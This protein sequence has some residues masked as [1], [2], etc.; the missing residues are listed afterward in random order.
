MKRILGLPGEEIEVRQGTVYV[1]GKPLS[2]PYVEFKDASDIGPGKLEADHFVAAGDNRRPTLIVVI[3]RKRIVGRWMPL[4]SPRGRARVGRE[5]SQRSRPA[6]G[7]ALA[8]PDR[9]TRF[10]Y[11]NFICA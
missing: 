9:F 4:W 10:Y 8:L 2:E 5:H 6:D 7:V 3:S 11:C 1:N